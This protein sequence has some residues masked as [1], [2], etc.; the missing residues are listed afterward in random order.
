VLLPAVNGRQ[1]RGKGTSYK[2]DASESV[3][4]KT[5]QESHS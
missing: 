1:T 2:K 3:Y 4:A 5:A